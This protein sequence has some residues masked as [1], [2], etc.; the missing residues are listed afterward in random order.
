MWGKTLSV[1]K[2]NLNY[3]QWTKGI[4]NGKHSEPNNYFEINLK[5]EIGYECLHFRRVQDKFLTE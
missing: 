4:W 3:F 2:K 1:E 5:Y